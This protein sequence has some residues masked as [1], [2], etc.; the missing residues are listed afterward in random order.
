MKS[1]KAEQPQPYFYELF[2]KI[3]FFITLSVLVLTM[4]LY[5]NFKEYSIKLL[6][7]SNEKLIGQIFQ[8]AL[9]I[10]SN[11]KTFTTALFTNPETAQLMYGENIQL[12]DILN[13][14]RSLEISIGSAPFIHSAYVY[15]GRTDTYYSIGPDS[16]IRRSDFYDKEIVRLLGGDKPLPS[17]DPIPRI[18]PPSQYRSS[19]NVSAYSY[20]MPE[21]FRDT[22]KVKNALVINVRMDWIFNTLTS[23]QESNSLEGNN[24]LILN[25]EGSV[26]AHSD[27]DW[28]LRNLSG[29]PFVQKILASPAKS[30]TLLADV[31]N[32]PSVITYV[33]YESPEWLLVNITPYKYIASTVDKVKTITLTIGISMLAVCLITAFLLSRN[34]YSPVGTLRK[35]IG[36]M[37]GPQT[38][39]ETHRSEFE[40]FTGTFQSAQQKL[41]LLESFKKSNMLRF[42]QQYLMDILSNK[43]MKQQDVE[44]RL[45]ECGIRLDPHDRI[46]VILFKIDDFAA[47]CE[48]YDD[49]DQ[50]LLKYA[51]TNIADETLSPH[52]RCDSVDAGS[53]HVVAIINAGG[54]EEKAG[55]QEERLEPLLAEIQSVYRVY[56]SVSVSAFISDPAEHIGQADRLYEKALELSHYRLISGHG[57]ILTQRRM[58]AIELSDFNI[59]HF[60]ISQLLDAI[61]RGKLEEAESKYLALAGAL[62]KCGYNNIMFALSHLSSSIFNTLNLIEKNGTNSFDLN[63]V[64]FDQTIKSLETLDQ[65][66][67]EFMALFKEIIGRINQNRDE[68]SEIVV[69]GAISHIERHYSDKA[70]SSAQVAD[71]VKLTPAYLNKLFRERFAM[72]VAD[73]ISD[74]RFLK[75]SSLLKETQLGV[76]EIIERIGWENKKYFFTVFKK[77]FGTTPTEYRLKA[78]IPPFRA[79]ED[80]RDEA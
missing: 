21:Y 70:L 11:V 57:C 18:I 51:L 65:I 69:A 62:E 48:K 38:L 40:F 36:Q 17:L 13:S 26:I 67:A 53:D 37:S 72:S 52:C 59:E 68:K 28:F 58:D 32:T 64:K 29:E 80:Q 50:A 22:K 19:S 25:R 49:S 24:I 5:V 55:I 35:T 33:S 42:K 27:R 66:N 20:V 56:C 79:R 12:M 44:H 23:Y 63:F 43:V 15:N 46:K 10:N 9:Q 34:L 31:G 7:M 74:I 76:D 75:A 1:K 61:K 41:A 3:T 30:G 78:A 60:V 73:Y 45:K 54:C 71:I 2:I 8:N 39:K 6:N 47:F 16:L 4:F 14:M 77:K